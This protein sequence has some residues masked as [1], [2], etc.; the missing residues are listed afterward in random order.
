VKVRTLVVP[1]RSRIKKQ[2][3]REGA[4]TSFSRGPA[5]SGASRACSMLHRDER[6]DELKEGQYA[7]RPEPQLR[8][9]PGQERPD[10]PSE[11]R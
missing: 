3:E 6:G 2:A 9:P 1:G 10:D 4:S 11:A 5:P 7:S 8:G